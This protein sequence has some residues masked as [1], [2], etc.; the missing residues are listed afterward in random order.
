MS[1]KR[2]P[3]WSDEAVIAD[4]KKYD[5][6]KDWRDNSS[7]YGVAHRRK[8]LDL[9]TA[10]MSPHTPPKYTSEEIISDARKYSSIAEWVR[11]NK[12]Y[13]EFA[14]RHGLHD[15]ATKHMGRAREV[16]D[17][18]KIAQEA[19][20]YQTKREWLEKGSKSYHIAHFRKI[21]DK[22][23]SHMVKILSYGEAV[24][25]KFLLERDIKFIHQHRFDDLFNVRKLRCDFFLPDF[26][27]VIEYNGIQHERGWNQDRENLDLIKKLDAIKIT[28]ILNH[29]INLLIVNSTNVAEI[30]SAV[31]S[32]LD[33]LAH[34]DS[35]KFA[36][37]VR[38]LTEE[39]L[40][41]I[42]NLGIWSKSE[43]AESAARF[44]SYLEWMTNEPSAYNRA[45]Q[46]GWLE[47]I[48]IHLERDRNP[49]GFWSKEA[50]IE[51]ARK[52]RTLTEWQK[53]AGA[54]PIVK[55]RK[56]GWFDE[57]TSHMTRAS[58][59]RGFWNKENVLNSTKRFSSFSEW[60]RSE[61][62]AVD[63]AHKNGWMDEIHAEFL[64]RKTQ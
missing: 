36:N 3:K 18:E 63:R 37:Q 64:K 11:S 45:R 44:T 27:L 43:V 17:D 29:G 12:R 50:V 5:T 26:N 15:E 60:S 20:K 39:E 40:Q 41:R 38:K 25:Y 2:A 54:A 9:A 24:I 56:M 30:N 51:S 48:A 33:E 19:R 7:A 32:K 31:S 35:L 57:A 34:K 58:R 22:V 10:H 8:L 14:K 46:M 1:L 61:R 47:E 4:A 13:Y 23:S 28:Y 49:R 6:I 55:A 62:G 21:V 52:F 59:P 42:E 16:W 53:G